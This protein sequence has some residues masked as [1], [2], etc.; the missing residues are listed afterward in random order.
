MLKVIWNF[1]Y[2]ITDKNGEARTMVLDISKA[3]DSDCNDSLLENQKVYGVRNKI[4]DVIHSFLQ[5]GL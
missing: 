2:Y 1:F 3:S 5:I 4:F